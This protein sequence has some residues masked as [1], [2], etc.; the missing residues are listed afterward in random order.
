MTAV[1]PSLLWKVWGLLPSSTTLLATTQ[2]FEIEQLDSTQSITILVL[3]R[4]SP[5]LFTLLTST[6]PSLG[7]GNDL[8]IAVYRRN[9]WSSIL[10]SG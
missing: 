9:F 6:Y 8:P 2:F 1:R 7:E 10:F 5:L 3:E 4:P